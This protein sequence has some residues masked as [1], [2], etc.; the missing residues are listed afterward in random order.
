MTATGRDAVK[1]ETDDLGV[2]T[3]SINRPDRM[4]AL[5]HH[6]V[7]ALIGL[8]T[9]HG[10]DAGTRVIVLAGEGAA[11]TT[12]ADLQSIREGAADAPSP[13][14]T[15]DNAAALVRAVLTA[16]VPVIAAV[17]GPAAGV[18]VSLAL[19][20][21]L[22]LMSDDAYLLFAFTNIGLMPD[23]GASVLLPAAVGR[24]VASRMLLRGDAVSAAEAQQVGLALDV[25]P[26]ADLRPAAAKLARRLAR[27]PRRA[28]ELTK[29]AVTGATLSE[30]DA[31]LAREHE[32][33]CE[34]L[35]SADFAEG[36]ASILE[37]R[38]PDFS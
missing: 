28:L 37:K 27:G 7:G 8:I 12:G 18:G 30:L 29:R 34:L 31:A 11:F 4:N 19:A 21:D 35:V 16:P 32:G 1:V 17:N 25:L 33:Q 26:A 23:G 36:V 13:D 14:V 24:S 2:T 20:S 5:D 6:T 15:M 38:R 3:I 10:A 22:V 9:E